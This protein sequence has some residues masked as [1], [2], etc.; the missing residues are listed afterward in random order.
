VTDGIVSEIPGTLAARYRRLSTD[1]GR[2]R[3]ELRSLARA[4]LV[5]ERELRTDADAR[6]DHG[7]FCFFRYEPAQRPALARLEA[8]FFARLVTHERADARSFYDDQYISSA[9]QLVLLALGRYRLVIDAREFVRR[10]LGAPGVT[11]KPY[12]LAGAVVC[13]RAAGVVVTA[14]DGGSLDFP[15]DATTPVGYAGYANE[16]TQRR[17]EPHWLAVLGAVG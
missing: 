11:S 8:D 14:A 5:A 6:A 13:A 17:L 1:R 3:F 2:C 16:P 10:R 4:E 15:I 9:G 7:Y 12:D